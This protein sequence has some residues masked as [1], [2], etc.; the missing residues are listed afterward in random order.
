MLSAACWNWST[1]RAWLDVEETIP[2]AK[3]VV[4][5]ITF[6]AVPATDKNG[7]GFRLMLD[8]FN[9]DWQLSSGEDVEHH[10][11]VPNMENNGEEDNIRAEFKKIFL[12]AKWERSDDNEDD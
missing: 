2:T 10:V 12:R 3:L 7:P 9:N 11:V 4:P 6:V 1:P 8:F 5:P